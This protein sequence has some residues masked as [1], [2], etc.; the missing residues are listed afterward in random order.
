M[1]LTADNVKD[2]RISLSW[3][4]LELLCKDCHD[5]ERERS[6]K[7]WSIGPDGSVIL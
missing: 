2:P 7:R 4:N 6:P 5:S 3:D 1:P